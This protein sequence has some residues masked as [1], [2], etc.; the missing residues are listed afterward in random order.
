MILGGESK[1][2]KKFYRSFIKKA[3]D[4]G[5][6][7]V[8]WD[9]N[10]RYEGT[11][12]GFD[13]TGDFLVLSDVSI[14][15]KEETLFGSE[16]IL[17]LDI[18]TVVSAGIPTGEPTPVRR[19]AHEES[20]APQEAQREV[21]PSVE[22][23]KEVPPISQ[24]S[25]KE[26]AKAILPEKKA[27]KPVAS[28]STVTSPVPKEKFSLLN[29]LPW[30]K[31]SLKVEEVAGVKPTPVFEGKIFEKPITPKPG[32]PKPVTSTGVSAPSPPS[33]LLPK[34]EG[35]GRESVKEVTK[36]SPTTPKVVPAPEEVKPQT[37][38]VTPRIVPPEVIE[39]KSA[40][41]STSQFFTESKGIETPSLPQRKFDIGTLILDILIVLLT[42]VAISIA[43]MGFLHVKLPFELPF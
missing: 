38:K 37:Q 20:F 22:V 29:L 1:V 19:V 12:K 34:K 6:V 13:P 36:P 42:L 24:E 26:E 17:P 27:E 28:P 21:L 5:R 4:E 35:I 41:V 30:R 9:G 3:A 31:S 16:I 39:K 14:A 32:T 33:P 7:I 2:S 15:E 18:L 40:Q 11:F 43:V 23:S 25:I 8:V 10:R